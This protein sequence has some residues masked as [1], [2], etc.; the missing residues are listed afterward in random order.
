MNE[1]SGER[2][3]ERARTAKARAGVASERLAELRDAREVGESTYA[4]AADAARIAV[5]R[6]DLALRRAA[7]AHHR[8]A[9]LHR[10]MARLLD[11]LGETRRAGDH[12]RLAAHDD[13]EASTVEA[14]PTYAR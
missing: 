2:A 1:R 12:R 11:T 9:D 13:A 14:V 8:A 3:A 6:A 7:Q 10:Q 4:P 5:D